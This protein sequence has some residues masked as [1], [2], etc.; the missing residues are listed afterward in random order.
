M[1]ENQAPAEIVEETAAPVE[2]APEIGT[3]PEDGTGHPPVLDDPTVPESEA[4]E[5]EA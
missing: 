4:V 5:P 2:A 1:D 3:P